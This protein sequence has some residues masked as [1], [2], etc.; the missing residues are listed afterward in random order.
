MI[1]TVS[2]SFLIGLVIVSFVVGLLSPVLL[3]IYYVANAD[4]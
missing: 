3:I 2:L 1:F 4:I